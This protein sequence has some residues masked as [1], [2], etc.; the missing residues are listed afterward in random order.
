M[1]VSV[2]RLPYWKASWKGPHARLWWVSGKCLSLEAA[3]EM[4]YDVVQG[5]LATVLFPGE[6][7]KHSE[8][9]YLE[10]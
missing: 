6:P 4:T 2:L 7:H 8:R 9:A 1:L 10:L 3:G 5:L